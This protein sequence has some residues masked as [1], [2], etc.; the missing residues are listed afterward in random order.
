MKNF[1]Q[2]LALGVCLTALA[3]P[4]VAQD[5]PNQV[6]RVVVP[7]A[8]GGPADAI[9]RIVT[10]RLSDILGQP[11]IIENRGG[12][13]GVIGTDLVAKGEPDGYI[14]GLSSAGAL[15]IS[16]SVQDVPYDATTDFAPVT[17]LLSVPELLVV[18]QGVPADSLDELIALGRENPGELAFASSGPGSMPHLAGELLNIAAEIDSLHV[19]YSGAAPA[20][21][22]VIGGQVDYMFADIPVLLSHVR[23]GTLRALAV[24]SAERAEILPEVPTTAELGW[25]DVT[26]EN[27]YGFVAPPGT[28]EEIVETLNAAILEALDDPAVA[29]ALQAQGATLIGS[30]PAEFGDYIASE[31]AKW[32]EVVETSG[33]MEDN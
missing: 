31:I 16:A 3:G 17:L 27:W 15:S 21:V 26:A 18:H 8:P 20:V 2:A 33:A 1:A 19:P 11:V 32:R 13:G 6:V 12:A 9:A 30:T 29:E 4:A 28:P 10:Q 23:E 7:F 22:D 24:G 25:P 5:Y 14:I